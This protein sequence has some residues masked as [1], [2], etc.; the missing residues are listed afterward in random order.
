MT[1]RASTE[2]LSL[3]S[4]TPQLTSGRLVSLDA[5]RGLTMF[6]MVVV[7][8]SGPAVYYQF[9]HATWNGW[10]LAD[11]VFP[12]FLWIVGVAI[13]LS[14]GKRL[15]AGAT[16]G[17]LLGHALRRSVILY[18]FGVF[19]Y[20]FPDFNFGHWR[21]TGVLQRIAV[22]YLIAA[23]IY[24][25]SGLKAQ[26][27]WTIAL[28]AV[29]WAA[30]KL[31]PVPGFGAG[32]LTLQ[33]N[34]AHYLDHLVLGDHNWVMTRTWDPEGLLSTLPA[35]A[36]TLLGVLA[37]YLLQMKHPM[38]QRGKWLLLA[39]AALV[40]AGSVCNVW[41]PIN[42]SLWTSSFAL[43]MAGLDCVALAALVWL[44]DGLGYR[45]WAHPL[46]VLGMNAIAVYM[47]SELVPLVLTLAFS[48]ASAG[49]GSLE[50]SVDNVSLLPA[51]AL[52][53]CYA[54]VFALGMY[55]FAWLLYRRKWFLRL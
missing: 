17:A 2:E 35:I 34:L 40:F 26:I 54:I 14:V 1:A 52:Q 25:Y 7:N 47:L 10:T 42:K 33:G 20:L 15:A 5:F 30:I 21:I 51:S 27:V 6:L 37:G 46:I 45:R 29:Y 3:R 19:I 23:C 41:L 53:F 18:A 36:T 39:G 55:A 4:E 50:N 9:H 8:S 11:T 43:F 38:A 13:T 28:L 49:R 16:R 31:I 24:M 48:K 32:N 22:C 12:S 44:I